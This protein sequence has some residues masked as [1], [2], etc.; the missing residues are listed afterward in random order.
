MCIPNSFQIPHLF[1]SVTH[2]SCDT[3]SIHP[4]PGKSTKIDQL[5]VAPLIQTIGNNS[6]VDEYV[7]L[8]TNEL[9]QTNLPPGILLTSPNA[10]SQKSLIIVGTGK[11]NL[12][13]L[14]YP[15]TIM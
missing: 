3:N 6:L 7:N 8:Q 15:I 10:D 14:H 12:Y 13:H 11:K 9:S 5:P 2:T 4:Q 1:L